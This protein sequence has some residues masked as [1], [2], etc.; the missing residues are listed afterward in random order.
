MTAYTP[1]S[2]NRYTDSLSHLPYHTKSNR[3]NSRTAQPSGIYTQHRFTPFDINSHTHQCIDK[4]YAVC[5]LSLNS[6]CNL[7]DVCHV[8]RQLDNQRFMITLT[9]SPNYACRPLTSHSEGHTAVF[10]VR[11]RYIQFYCRDIL[12]SIYSC[13][14]FRIIFRRRATYIHNHVRVDILYFRVNMF[15]EV[16]HTLILEPHAIQHP[17]SCFCHTRIIITL[18]RF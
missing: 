6:T 1:K 13:G 14:T 15:T 5:A 18:S 10:H 11:T 17:R 12:Q 16:V 4:R 9:Y 3:L 2:Y 7:C 8:W